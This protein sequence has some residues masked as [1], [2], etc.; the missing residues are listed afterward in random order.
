MPAASSLASA[1]STGAPLVRKVTKATIVEVGEL[2]ELWESDRAIRDRLRF[3]DGKLVQ[4]VS[5]DLINKPTMASIALNNSA[6]T[7]LA[8]WWCK[9]QGSPKSPSVLDLKKEAHKKEVNNLYHLVIHSV[10][11]VCF[12]IQLHSIAL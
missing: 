1:G 7:H 2:A 4:W 8:S 3:N 6:L 5:D 12:Q 10:L 9:K 11:F